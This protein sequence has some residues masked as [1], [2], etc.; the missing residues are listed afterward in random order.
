MATKDSLADESRLF[1]KMTSKGLSGFECKYALPE[2]PVLIVVT[3]VLR[4]NEL[5]L[6]LTLEVFRL[7]TSAEDVVEKLPVLFVWSLAL[8]VEASRV[9]LA[10]MLVCEMGLVGTLLLLILF[11]LRALIIDVRLLAGAGLLWPLFELMDDLA[12][13]NDVRLVIRPW[14]LVGGYPGCVGNVFVEALM[15][16]PGSHIWSLPCSSMVWPDTR[17]LTFTIAWS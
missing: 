4:D 16:G 8:G 12:C 9:A 3:A 10:V 5:E 2:L 7:L 15:K 13:V 17:E 6:V 1:R 11:L 14:P